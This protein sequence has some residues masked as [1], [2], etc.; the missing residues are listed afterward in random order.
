MTLT[1]PEDRWRLIRVGTD[2][3]AQ[4]GTRTERGERITAEWGEPD[5]D[6]IYEPTFTAH[7]EG[8]VLVT[9]DGLAAAI[10]AAAPQQRY[11]GTTKGRPTQSR[12]ELA[13]AILRHLR[14]TPS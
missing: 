14:D 4:F 5:A 6:G 8:A 7:Y 3:L 1:D 10:A 2:L 13:A 12:Q 9:E 11:F